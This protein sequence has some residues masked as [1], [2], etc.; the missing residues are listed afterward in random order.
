MM[1]SDGWVGWVWMGCFAPPEFANV[2][3][4]RWES[5]YGWVGVVVFYFFTRVFNCVFSQWLDTFH[6]HTFSNSG[7]HRLTPPTTPTQPCVRLMGPSWNFF[8]EVSY[9]APSDIDSVHR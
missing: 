8:Q 9:R 4:C 3:V 2:C 5:V 1:Q 7:G 6:T